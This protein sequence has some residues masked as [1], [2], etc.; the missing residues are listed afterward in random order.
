[1]YALVNTAHERQVWKKKKKNGLRYHC[2]PIENDVKIEK[3]ANR[4]G[5][6]GFSLVHWSVQTKFALRW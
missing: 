1:M 2:L 5:D 6:Q 3:M 4:L